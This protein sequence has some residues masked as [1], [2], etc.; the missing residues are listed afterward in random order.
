MKDNLIPIK[1][2][3]KMLGISYKT[4]YEWLNNGKISYTKIGGRYYLTQEQLNALV[5]IYNKDNLTF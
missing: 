2:A 5:L 1:E 3:S 4:I